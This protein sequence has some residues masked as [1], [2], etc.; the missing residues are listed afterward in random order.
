MGNRTSSVLFDDY[1][2]Q[3]YHSTKND[4]QKAK[5]FADF[6][7][8]NERGLKRE[9][10]G[11]LFHTAPL[12]HDAPSLLAL[13]Q[14]YHVYTHDGQSHVCD[15]DVVERS[16]LSCLLY[17]SLA[18]R[19]LPHLKGDKRIAFKMHFRDG[20]SFDNIPYSKD[21]KAVVTFVKTRFGKK[22]FT[23]VYLDAPRFEPLNIYELSKDYQ[24]FNEEVAL[25]YHAAYRK[26]RDVVIH[27]N[28]AE[29]IMVRTE[30]C[31]GPDCDEI[32]LEHL[33]ALH[34]K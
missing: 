13:H 20:Q 25:G 19:L 15:K 33:N 23:E 8:I 30:F 4:L 12:Q 17:K 32:L 24:P 10:P 22:P 29:L 5:T 3:L 1:Y 9:V 28:I 21:R 6:V 31:K 14:Q 2:N 18:K 16:Y 34:P 27:E 26:F 7:R 11:F